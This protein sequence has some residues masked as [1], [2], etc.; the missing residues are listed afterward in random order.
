MLL[1]VRDEGAL[2]DIIYLGTRDWALWVLIAA[3]ILK[4]FP[5]SGSLNLALDQHTPKLSRYFR[6]TWRKVCECQASTKLA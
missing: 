6:R 5:E 1:G 4:S 3:S 2:M